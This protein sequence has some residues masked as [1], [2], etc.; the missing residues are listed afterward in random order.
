MDLIVKNIQVGG[1]S[2]KLFMID[3]FVKDE[4]MEKLLEALM[5]VKE[6]D[7]PESPE[8]FA[9]M[10]PHIEVDTEKSVRKAV[11]ALMSGITIMLM[12]GYDVGFA[13]DCRTY[14]S[15]SVSEPW[16]NR[17]L[18]GPNYA[19][20]VNFW[21]PVRGSIGIHDAPWRSEYGGEIYKTNGSHGCINTPYEEME[22]I[23]DH[24]EIGTPV[25]MFY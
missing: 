11:T 1:K 8:Q 13:I 14:P 17:V 16:K 24:V 10:I 19:S 21:V 15:R 4:L 9:D 3:C 18:R 20:F 6:D 12:E 5:A 2:A 23:Y 22:K 7:V 25:V